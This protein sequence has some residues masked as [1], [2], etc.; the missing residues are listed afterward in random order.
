[1]S[2][3]INRLTPV[4]RVFLARLLILA[5]MVS[6]TMVLQ[7]N[8]FAWRSMMRTVN[9]LT[10]ILLLTLGQAIVIIGGGLDLSIGASLSLITVV[11]TEV[12]QADVPISG[13]WALLIGLLVALAMG[14]VNG[15][16]VGYFRIPTV[17]VTF[18]TSYIWLGISLFLQPTPGGE[19]VPWFRIFYR[20]REISGAPAW[21]ESMIV[22]IPP[23]VF[24]IAVAALFWSLVSRTPFGTH[25]YAVG[26]DMDRAFESG[27]RPELVKIGAYLISSFFVFLVAVFLVAQNGT[28]DA[29]MGAPLTLQSVA[30]AVVGG[31]VLTGG[32]GTL[33]SASLGAIILMFVG[34]IIFFA[35]VPSAFQT[36]VSGMVII[37]AL[38]S[39]DMLGR[40]R[41]ETARMEAI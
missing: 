17:I 22:G 5:L 18:A 9:S 28:G 4:V 33:K 39:S 35:R 32:V 38:A 34:Q 20:I 21:L 10:P 24:L 2:N 14:L 1:M 41:A 19:S 3:Y 31:I 30:A 27:I 11:L 7:N 8:F 37:V 29:R 13:V 15:V 23:A 25:L 12:M 6:I 26:T 36:L 40:K 16:A